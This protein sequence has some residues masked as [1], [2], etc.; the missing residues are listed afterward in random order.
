[1]AI[2]DHQLKPEMLLYQIFTGQG[3]QVK[4]SCRN[5]TYNSPEI[6]KT[7]VIII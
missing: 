6:K 3:G 7:R 5:L 1:M 4:V 2:P